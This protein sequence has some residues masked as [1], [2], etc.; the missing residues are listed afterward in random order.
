MNLLDHLRLNERAT[1]TRKACAEGDAAPCTVVLR[2]LRGD[3]LVYEPVNACILFRR[4]GR[5]AEVITVEDL[6]DCERC[7]HPVQQLMADLQR[8][9]CGFC[10]PAL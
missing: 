6:G 9:A 4:P 5:R 2:R 1:G 3:N 10:T 8:L 7:I